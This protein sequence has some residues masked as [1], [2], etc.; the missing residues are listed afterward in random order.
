MKFQGINYTV[1]Q[2]LL[3]SPSFLIACASEK[4]MLVYENPV[5]K[6]VPVTENP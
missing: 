2:S 1:L 3:N 5:S 6:S 4:L